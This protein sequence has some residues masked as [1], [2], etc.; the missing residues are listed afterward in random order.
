MDLSSV[1]SHLASLP[2]IVSLIQQ[3]TG[4][5]GSKYGMSTISLVW[6]VCLTVKVPV[7]ARLKRRHTFM[8][9]LLVPSVV[10]FVPPMLMPL[11]KLLVLIGMERQ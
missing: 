6:L 8:I 10:L 7:S 4:P 9:T 11:L 5:A 1:P 3:E 2:V